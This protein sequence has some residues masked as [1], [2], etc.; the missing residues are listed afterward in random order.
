MSQSLLFCF[1]DFLL[2]LY[3]IIILEWIFSNLSFLEFLSFLIWKGFMSFV[4]FG[5]FFTIISS[6]ILTAPFLFFWDTYNARACSCPTGLLGSVGFLFIVFFL[7]L[8]IYSFIWPVYKF[9]DSFILVTSTE[10]N[11]F[12]LL[13]FQLQS[14]ILFLIII[15]ISSLIIT[16]N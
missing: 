9:T 13:F 8:R 7:L 6:N 10:L 1:L 14:F 4:T 12:Q 11:S 3:S 16:E 15:C 5:K 2:P